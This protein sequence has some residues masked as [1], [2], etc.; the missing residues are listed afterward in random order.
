MPKTFGESCIT[1]NEESLDTEIAL[2]GIIHIRKHAHRETCDQ[3][4][5]FQI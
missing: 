5:P 2:Y 1:Y 3:T 4:R